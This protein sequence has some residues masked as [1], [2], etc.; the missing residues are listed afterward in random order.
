MSEIMPPVGHVTKNEYEQDRPER[1]MPLFLREYQEYL[2]RFKK[3]ETPKPFFA[4]D[5][6]VC[7]RGLIETQRFM[8][9]DFEPV[10]P[11]RLPLARA[12]GHLSADSLG[13]VFSKKH[14]I[15]RQEKGY[16]LDRVETIYPPTEAFAAQGRDDWA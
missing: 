7:I 13:I 6:I 2:L 8:R 14:K 16:F 1:V 4:S 3:S 9:I 15:F 10:S 5:F 11:D 12:I